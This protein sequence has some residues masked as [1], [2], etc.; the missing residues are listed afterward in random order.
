MVFSERKVVMGIQPAMVSAAKRVERSEFKH[1][2]LLKGSSWGARPDHESRPVVDD[3]HHP[4]GNN[5]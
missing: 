4:S 1:D 3:G 2:R 5:R